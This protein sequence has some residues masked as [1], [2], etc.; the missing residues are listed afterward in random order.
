VDRPE[1][2]ALHLIPFPHHFRLFMHVK[3]GG[4]LSGN[5]GISH[6]RDVEL[7]AEFLFQQGQAF[8]IETMAMGTIKIRKFNQLHLS[9]N[10]GGWFVL[11]QFEFTLEFRLGG[12]RDHE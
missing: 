11:E 7:I 8:A 5:D 9:R 4:K 10:M 12:M 2:D 1:E 6:H 3:G